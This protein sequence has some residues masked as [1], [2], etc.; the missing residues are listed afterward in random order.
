MPRVLTETE[1]QAHSSETLANAVEN[2]ASDALRRQR[3][4]AIEAIKTLRKKV[5]IASPM[6]IEEIISMRDEGRR[7]I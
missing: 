4:E 1:A 6:T 7:Y 3:E 5:M 2:K